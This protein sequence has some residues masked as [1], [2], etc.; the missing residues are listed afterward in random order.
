MNTELTCLKGF[1]PKSFND[2]VQMQVQGGYSISKKG[3]EVESPF[4]FALNQGAHGTCTLV[5]AVS[6][7]KIKSNRYR[8]HMFQGFH[9]RI[10]Q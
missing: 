5:L 4:Y 9:S 1:T 7:M 6:Y 3:I 10:V 2:L 8:P